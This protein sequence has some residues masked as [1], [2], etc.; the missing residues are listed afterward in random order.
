[1]SVDYYGVIVSVLLHNGTKITGTVCHVDPTTQQLT[2]KNATL[3]FFGEP[4]KSPL[5]GIYG[6]D[7][8][9][10]VTELPED[11]LSKDFN[12]RT[13]QELK[14][15]LNTKIPIS[16]SET[17]SKNNKKDELLSINQKMEDYS[18]S[19]QQ[20]K[21]NL[22]E[23]ISKPREQPKEQPQ[24]QI[25]Q[26]KEQPQKQKEQLK[27]QP[28][29]QKEQLKEQPQKQK[30]RHGKEHI[31]KQ[32][33][34][35]KQLQKNEQQKQKNLLQRNSPQKE[36]SCQNQLFKEFP[37]KKRQLQMKQTFETH[38]LK[39]QPIKNMPDDTGKSSDKHRGNR[40]KGFLPQKNINTL[41][42]SKKPVYSLELIDTSVNNVN[43][44]THQSS[45]LESSVRPRPSSSQK[46]K[47]KIQTMSQIDCPTFSLESFNCIEQNY[48]AKSRQ[49]ENDFY[50]KSARGAAVLVTRILRLASV[51]YNIVV[52]AGN[53]KNGAVALMMVLQLLT[54]IDCSVTVYTAYSPDEVLIDSFRKEQSILLGSEAIFVDC[55]SDITSRI[56]LIVEAILDPEVPLID[57]ASIFPI[58][59]KA[60]DWINKQA[61][62]IMSIDFPSGTDGNTGIPYHPEYILRP[63]WTIALGA[64]KRGCTSLKVTGRVYLVDTGLTPFLIEQY[65]IDMEPV[66]SSGKAL[67]KLLYTIV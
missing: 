35:K 52:I 46:V 25:E 19:V 67:V 10:L 61:K 4:Y 7:I 50:A 5:H 11:N 15:F 6:K 44:N 38:N 63:Q 28:Q 13:N 32:Q 47:F 58:A 42:K 20:Q 23:Q 8:R 51:P 48:L 55:L 66:I 14:T 49:S 31:Q 2:L 57:S 41:D 54:T 12:Q 9:E 16:T 43:L 33:T 60:I 18:Q 64:L 53:N 26:L 36:N 56:D 40:K 30:E 21:E 45:S 39:Q 17:M 34:T 24:K 3:Y 27:E 29:K 62:P 37:K 1:M 22:K 65:D 59:A